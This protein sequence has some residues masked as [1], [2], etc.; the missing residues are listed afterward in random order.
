VLVAFF[1]IGAVVG[2]VLIAAGV[3]LFGWWLVSAIRK[4]DV[5]D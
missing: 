4:A 2:I 5:S 3:I 1:F